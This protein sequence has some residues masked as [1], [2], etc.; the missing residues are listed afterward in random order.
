M[1]RARQVV[2]DVDEYLDHAVEEDPEAVLGGRRHNGH[3]GHGAE[4]EA[5]HA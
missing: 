1:A 2:A 5:A 3:N 4:S